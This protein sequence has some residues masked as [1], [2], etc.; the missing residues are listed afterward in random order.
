MKDL[1]LIRKDNCE[2]EKS[3]FIDNLTIITDMVVYLQSSD[4]CEYD[5]EIMR[6]DLIG[7]ALE[8][9]L[10]GEKLSNVIGEDYKSFCNELILS[11]DIKSTKKK[12]LNCL[13]GVT[14][15]IGFM[16]I[17]EIFM[18]SCTS[19]KDT[20]KFHMP[21]TWGFILS[22]LLIIVAGY[23]ILKFIAKNSFK[24]SDKYSTRAINLFGI[25]FIMTFCI[26]GLVKYF[27]RNSVIGTINYLYALIILLV[28]LAVIKWVNK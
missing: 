22:T 10:R 15:V 23:G 19:P 7:M 26:I 1:K 28:T 6:K 5:I 13:F 25:S 2:Q 4:L 24:L 21:I 27:L 8:A 17:L 3:L 11:G 12:I 9:Q 14:V 16:F 18:Y 20:L